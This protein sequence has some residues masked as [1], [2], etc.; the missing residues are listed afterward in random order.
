MPA[1]DFYLKLPAQLFPTNL[2]NEIWDQVKDNTWTKRERIIEDSPESGARRNQGN[3]TW[4]KTELDQNVD[5]YREIFSSNLSDTLQEV[6][7]HDD[8][9]LSLQKIKSDKGRAFGVHFDRD[10]CSIQMV[11]SGDKDTKIKFWNDDPRESMIFNM[12]GNFPTC[13][14]EVSYNDDIVYLNTV[15]WHN[16][17]GLM[18]DRYLLRF[19]LNLDQQSHLTFDYFRKKLNEVL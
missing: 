10:I 1:S 3:L 13:D 14:A 2:R 16:N 9:L 15:R 6:I 4:W 19:I 12:W 17:N 5:R 11:I 7:R 8:V 18:E